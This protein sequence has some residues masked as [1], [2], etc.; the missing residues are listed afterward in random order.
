MFKKFWMLSIL[1]I[2]CYATADLESF[3]DIAS[4]ETEVEKKLLKALAKTETNFSKYS[5]GI[6][7]KNPDALN[8]FFKNNQIKFKQRTTHFSLFINDK[9]TA[10]DVYHKFKYF[11]HHNPTAIKTYDLGLMQINEA[12]MKEENEKMFYLDTKLNA[13][14]AGFI[15][16]DCF[17]Y[18]NKNV[19][20][21]IECY[22]KGTNSKKFGNFEYFQ[23]VRANYLQL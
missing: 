3:F 1:V 4:K 20:F 12:N 18:F 15:L 6:I 23:K 8:I 21:A 2:S 10:I 5:I 9:D 13:I 22:N 14:Y 7:A 16:Q 11:I 19:K 17:N